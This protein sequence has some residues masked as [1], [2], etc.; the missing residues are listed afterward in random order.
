MTASRTDLTLEAAEALSPDKKIFSHDGL[1][2]RKLWRDGYEVTDLRVTSDHAARSLEKP[3]GHYITLDLQPYFQRQRD[4]FARAVRC[5]AREIR[6]LL[7]NCSGIVLVVGLGN[8]SL[9]ADA[10]GPLALD[11]L[12]VTRHLVEKEG[13]S[14][15]RP[16]AAIATGVSSETGLEAT[17][18]VQ[19]L[20]EK[21]EPCAVICID[22][23]CARSRERLC[24]TIQLSDTGLQ[25]GSGVRN[26]RKAL[27]A[28]TLHI[29]VI[30]IGV[31]TVID[32][33]T[34]SGQECEPLF[35]T[36]GDID[37]RVRELSR[38]VGFGITSAL[39]PG[40]SVEDITGLLG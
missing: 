34:L 4:F 2:I 6:Q 39:Q 38:M 13:F 20:V 29:P 40:L 21:T 17:E 37:S 8:R 27:T 23:L 35:L 28:E 30:A 33:T 7:G 18:L 14:S 9:T 24:A 12:L 3:Q 11:N 15:F 1:N 19:S 32:A 5:L 10:V 22:S 26:H 16:V 36:P 25:P 31:P